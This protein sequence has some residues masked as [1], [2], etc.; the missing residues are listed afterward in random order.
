[1]SGIV[2]CSAKWRI[3]RFMGTCWTGRWMFFQARRI[4]SWWL[5]LY[6]CRNCLHSTL[7]AP[8]RFLLFVSI[9]HS[10][11]PLLL[12]NGPPFGW[13]NKGPKKILAENRM[14]ERFTLETNTSM[15]SVPVKSEQGTSPFAKAL[16]FLIFANNYDF[17]SDYL[18][19]ILT[20]RWNLITWTSIHI[21]INLIENLSPFLKN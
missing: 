14:F 5:Q 12:A 11:F 21:V 18:D 7:S 13:C 1:M 16:F 4:R 8:F 2:A 10:Y 20:D 9:F 6:R 15:G 3:W 17:I 19:T